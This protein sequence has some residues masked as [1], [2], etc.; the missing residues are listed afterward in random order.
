MNKETFLELLLDTPFKYKDDIE[1]ILPKSLEEQVFIYNMT[2][3]DSKIAIYYINKK[4]E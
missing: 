3:E 1:P 2:N 4:D